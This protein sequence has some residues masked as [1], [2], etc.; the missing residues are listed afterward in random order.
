MFNDTPLIIAEDA[1]TLAEVTARLEKAPVIGV[2]TES[3]SFYSYQEKVCLIQFSDMH[4]DY[5]VDPLKVEDLSPLARVM[6]SKDTVKVFHGGDYDIVCLRRDY[7]WSIHNVFDTLIA[8]QLLGLDRLGLADL[9]GRFYGH[10]ID[11]KYQRYDWSRRPLE[12]DHF[13]YARG[14]TH[15]LISL[16]EIL[17]TRL[18]RM[19]R[20]AHSEEECLLLEQ[21]EWAGRAFD[22]DGY[23]RIKGSARLDDHQKR[24]LRRLYLYRDEQARKQN[25]PTFKVLPDGALISVATRLPTN[26][27]ELN[28]VFTK[29]VAMK[30]RHGDYLIE[31]VVSGLEDTFKVPA[32]KKKTKK[33]SSTP[34]RISGRAAERAMAELKE[35]RNALCERDPRF[36]PFNVASNS[37]L[38]AIANFRPTNL[39]ELA[40]IKDVRAWQVRDHG[41]QILAVLDEHESGSARTR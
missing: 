1:D 30:R 15:W 13:D 6:E 5:I 33:Q 34:A 17:L 31:A 24:V 38:K 35:W 10:Y 18:R 21:R 7:D 29:Q 37:T 4:G 41:V 27:H 8:A 26:E 23:L 2:D 36:T 25:R 12:E 3:D 28:K 16:R 39:E 9:I 20:I 14:D 22:P 11:K 40:Q 19:G 32:P